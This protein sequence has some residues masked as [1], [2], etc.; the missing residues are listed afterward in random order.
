ML[1]YLFILIRLPSDGYRSNFVTG[2]INTPDIPLLTDSTR[3]Y[4]LEPLCPVTDSPALVNWRKIVSFQ[5]GVWPCS[6]IG[7]NCGLE[8][9]MARESPNVYLKFVI[10]SYFTSGFSAHF[11]PHGFIKATPIN[12][13]QFEL[14]PLNNKG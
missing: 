9:H 1:K 7:Y 8:D 14:S 4:S 2:A 13:H 11:N 10:I 5:A 3:S 6:K 12:L